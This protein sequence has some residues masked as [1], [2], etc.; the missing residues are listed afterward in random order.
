MKELEVFKNRCHGPPIPSVDFNFLCKYFRNEK[1][2]QRNANSWKLNQ[3][4]TKQTDKY[5]FVN[6]RS[7]N[8]CHR[9]CCRIRVVLPTARDSEAAVANVVPLKRR[10]IKFSIVVYEQYKE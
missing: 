7:R 5:N 6:P 10:L 3:D 2:R 4:P 1:P 8:S 9:S